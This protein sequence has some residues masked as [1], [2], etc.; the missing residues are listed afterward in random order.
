MTGAPAGAPRP[1][2]SLAGMAYMVAVAAV[3]VL[4]L[5]L[6]ALYTQFISG[7]RQI[8]RITDDTSQFYLAEA[9]FAKTLNELKKK[10]WSHWQHELAKPRIE[11]PTYRGASCCVVVDT[12]KDTR[13]GVVPGLV[14]IFVRVDHDGCRMTYIE[15]AK[16]L[17]VSDLRPTQVE[18][19]RHARL[20]YE[21]DDAGGRSSAL[22][23]LGQ[24]ERL[25]ELN[26]P[27]TNVNV[28]YARALLDRGHPISRTVEL[29]RQLEASARPPSP[30]LLTETI[31][32][33]VRE[34]RPRSAR[35]GVSRDEAARERNRA[36][37][38]VWDRQARSRDLEAAALVAELRASSYSSDVEKERTVL[39]KIRKGDALLFADSPQ[40]PGVSEAQ[41]R[42]EEA[43]AAAEAQSATCR[44]ETVPRCLFRLAQC[45]AF[46]AEQLPFE[47]MEPAPG[48]C[49]RPVAARSG[50]A[51]RTQ[52]LEE[53]GQLYR[54]ITQTYRGSSEAAHAH[55]P[56]AWS[57]M[58]K[59][60][61]RDA[62]SWNV[63]RDCAYAILETLRREY[64][65]Y[66]LWHEHAITS[67]PGS[68]GHPAPPTDEVVYY[69]ESLIE[70]LVVLG[71][72]TG[73]SPRSAD[74]AA[75]RTVLFVMDLNVDHPRYLVPW[76]VAAHREQAGPVWTP[77]GTKVAFSAAQETGSSLFDILLV[78]LASPDRAVVLFRGTARCAL[79]CSPDGQRFLWNHSSEGNTDIYSMKI[80]G[81]DVRRLTNH[82]ADDGSM[83]VSP[84]G[85]RVV[86]ASRRVAGPAGEQTL[87]EMDLDG[88]NLRQV[89]DLEPGWT[90]HGPQYSPD[91]SQISF[92]R[93][94]AGGGNWPESRVWTMA[95]DGSNR[96]PL[97]PLG[98][99]AGIW[100]SDGL[101]RILLKLDEG[102]GGGTI[103]LMDPDGSNIRP[104]GGEGGRRFLER[105]GDQT[106]WAKFSGASQ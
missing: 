21:I 27:A 50:P 43:L 68:T 75:C 14:D 17:Q 72:V 35:A 70:P 58:K 95:R 92:N 3:L 81:S 15:R 5:V 41:T 48:G 32:R 103:W 16:L 57:V 39:S 2:R 102:G 45:R 62:R 73:R 4:G 85:R 51:S 6:V 71:R 44:K 79:T 99:H 20:E 60:T 29:V 98:Y 82:A 69:V 93:W 80:D 11:R 91:G 38:T 78:D 89:T 106:W 23:R 47:R 52:L 54:Q 88:S 74:E 64:P 66:H 90:H 100:S 28:R 18:L 34:F 9:L 36:A 61:T 1:G 46:R 10:P 33:L 53:A 25:R 76:L 37:S 94:R 19:R 63:A 97:T 31:D 83:K 42:Y 40:E 49:V 84:D 30:P 55:I 8:A 105:V 22:A 104:L 59:V 13:G 65:L 87:W 67:L 86:F 7:V 26:R 77:D 101:A 12:V 96:R 56:W 24:E